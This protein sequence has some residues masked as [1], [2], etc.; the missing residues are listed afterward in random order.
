MKR[1]LQRMLDRDEFLSD[2]RHPLALASTIADHPYVLRA[3]RHDTYRRLRARRVAH[4][5]VRR[6]LELA[7]AGLVPVNFLLIE[8]LQKFH[9]YYGDDF[10]VECPTGSG[11][12]LTLWEVADELSRRLIAALPA[13][14]ARAAARCSATTR[15]IRSTTRTG[16]T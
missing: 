1:L 7:R 6:Q 16:A 13:R 2:L 5:P 10:K 9:H 4:R 14:R 11:N 8:A 3:R 15:T 12:M